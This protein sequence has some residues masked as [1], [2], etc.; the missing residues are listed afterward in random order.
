MSFLPPKEARTGQRRPRLCFAFGSDIPSAATAHDQAQVLTNPVSSL[1]AESY[2]AA[3]AETMELPDNEDGAAQAKND[4]FA[5]LEKGVEDKRRG[6]EGAERIAELREDSSAKYEDDYAINK[7]LR[8]QLRY[9][10]PLNIGLVAAAC[11][12]RCVCWFHGSLQADLQHAL[13]K[14]SGAC[15]V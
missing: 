10:S 3:D 4:P 9:A 8:R 14:V 1:Q 7:A 5:R 15:K 13:W 12:V 6:R 11:A 2:T